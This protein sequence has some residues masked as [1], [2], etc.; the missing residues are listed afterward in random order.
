MIIK[1][2]NNNK[3]TN[4]ITVKND[5]IAPTYKQKKC[6]CVLT[7]KNAFNFKITRK[8]ASIII[9]GIKNGTDIPNTLCRKIGVK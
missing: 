7:G 6:L 4:K 2:I 8:E 9:G 1:A 3:K 5:N